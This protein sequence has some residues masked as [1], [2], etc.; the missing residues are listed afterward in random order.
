ME[1]DLLPRSDES[2]KAVD[3]VPIEAADGAADVTSATAARNL[4]TT[5]TERSGNAS[6]GTRHRSAISGRYVTSASASRHPNTT[7]TKNG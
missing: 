3:A 7:V 1:A 6:A 5:V 2:I 4:R